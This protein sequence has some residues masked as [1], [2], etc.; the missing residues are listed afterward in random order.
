MSRRLLVLFVLA[1][2]WC[3]VSCTGTTRPDFV[4]H[5]VDSGNNNPFEQCNSGTVRIDVQQ[6]TNAVLTSNGNIT[7][8]AISSLSVEIPSYGLTT[9]IEVTVSC[10]RRTGETVTL[11]G[12]TP[13]FIPVGYAFV[14]VVLHEPDGCVALGT[15]SLSSARIGPHLVPLHAN[16]VS[17]GGSEGSD[18]S[19]S[20]HVQVLDALTFTSN[21]AALEFDRLSIG[22]GRGH[23]VAIGDTQIVFASDAQSGVFDGAASLTTRVTTPSGGIHAGAG[24]ESAVLELNGNGAVIVGGVSGGDAVDGVTWISADG[25][26][27]TITHLA[28]ARRRPA[29]TL[30]GSNRVLVVGGQASGEPLFELVLIGDDATTSFG[31]TEARYGALVTSDAGHGHDRALVV[32]GED[33]PEGGAALDTTWIV[34]ACMAASGCSAVAG[35][36]WASPRTDATLLEHVAGVP[37]AA[38][39]TDDFEALVIGGV[40]ASGVAASTVDR[41]H[42]ETDGSVTLSLAGELDVARAGAG[43]ADVGAGVVLVGGG[44]SDHGDPLSSLELCFPRA[45][46]P[47]GP[48]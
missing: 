22:I 11:I 24:S 42:F 34:S 31:P 19:P 40:D 5:L 9:Q 35:P 23:A 1:H 10:V 27:S 46:R 8:G 12:A 44:T 3:A 43:A 37:G 41:I 20:T 33:A 48:G 7:G 38:A 36:T 15:P 28:H 6:A 47:I 30:V 18:G 32:L 29:A 16:V 45:L 26:T 17:I 14:D 13:H 25:A 39:P 4:V 2:A 21:V